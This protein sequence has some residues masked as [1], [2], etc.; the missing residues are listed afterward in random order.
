MTN[1]PINPSGGPVLACD[2]DDFCEVLD[3]DSLLPDPPPSL[4]D[5][6]EVPDYVAHYCGLDYLYRHRLQEDE[7]EPD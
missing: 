5:N 6:P 7:S 1:T 3:C 4:V 2:L